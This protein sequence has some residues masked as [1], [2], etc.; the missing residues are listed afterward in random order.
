MEPERCPAKQSILV[1]V[2]ASLPHVIFAMSSGLYRWAI[3]TLQ[4]R[5]EQARRSSLLHGEIECKMQQAAIE[6]AATKISRL[7]MVSA[8]ANLTHEVLMRLPHIFRV[9]RLSPCPPDK[10]PL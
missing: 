3:E 6:I 4:S 9:I 1:W 8:K 7:R 10:S 2:S 5:M